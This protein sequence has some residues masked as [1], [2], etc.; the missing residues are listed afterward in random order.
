M[1]LQ[2]ALTLIVLL[3]VVTITQARPSAAIASG[4]PYRDWK[5]IFD[6]L[7]KPLTTI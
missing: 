2:L 7:L 1:K 3:A 5:I 4:G 6:V